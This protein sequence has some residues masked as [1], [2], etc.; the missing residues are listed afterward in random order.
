MNKNNIINI[1][2]EILKKIIKFKQIYIK[3]HYFIIFF[4]LAP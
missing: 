4:H 1:F 3:F 2:C